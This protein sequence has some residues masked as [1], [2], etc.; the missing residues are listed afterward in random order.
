M[1]GRFKSFCSCVSFSPG[2]HGPTFK[3]SHTGGTCL[4][5]CSRVT[6]C[7]VDSSRVWQA[8]NSGNVTRL[9][10]IT[11]HCQDHATLKVASYTTLRKR[12]YCIGFLQ[13]RED[14]RHAKLGGIT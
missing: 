9:I 10:G 12:I 13:S 2:T 6:F 8:L 1:R 4:R 7:S 5:Q 14:E 3:T 11:L